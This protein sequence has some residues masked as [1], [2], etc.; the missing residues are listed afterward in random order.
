MMQD[1]QNWI[2]HSQT[3]ADHITPRLVESY[4]AILDGYLSP[5]GLPGL[6]W[7][8]APIIEET[9]G[10][11]VDGH[12]RTGGFLPPV[13]LPRRMAAGGE[14]EF[15]APLQPG[16]TVEK[17]STI[18][19]IAWKTGKTGKLCFVTVGHDYSTVRGLAIRETQ[20]IVY[21]A[22]ATAQA[23]PRGAQGPLPDSG[24]QGQADACGI[25]AS[26]RHH[27]VGGAGEHIALRNV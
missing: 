27:G 13:R 12:P 7:C 11:G 16:D 26:A 15:R 14:L 22:A 10:L 4:G 3:T 18:Q 1:L 9:S 8:L 17:V 24:G 5:I 6:Q 20:H 19:E 21:R 25:E 23:P 2:G